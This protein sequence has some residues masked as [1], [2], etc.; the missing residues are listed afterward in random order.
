MSPLHQN[1]DFTIQPATHA[2]MITLLTIDQLANSHNDRQNFIKSSIREKS[3][4]LIKSHQQIIGYGVLE[5]SF[6]GKGFISMLYI[7]EK[8]RRK[9][10]GKTLLAY[11]ES[12]CTVDKLFT[13]TN[14]SNFP[15]Q[16][17]LFN[18][19]YIL[20]G[21]VQNLDENDPE[22]FFFKNVKL[23]EMNPSDSSKIP[24]A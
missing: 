4:H 17:L 12:I 20:S 9:G 7:D 23:H 5:Y 22:L 8:F 21:V 14:L 24:I 3:C 2:D 15:M 6:F 11:L 16:A 10:A 1:L 19:G 13:S 18:S